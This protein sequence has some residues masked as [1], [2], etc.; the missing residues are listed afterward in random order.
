[1]ISFCLL[2]LYTLL[3][4]CLMAD[5]SLERV[6]FVWMFVAAILII[7]L[8]CMYLTLSFL[9]KFYLR[10]MSCTIWW[11]DIRLPSLRLLILRLQHFCKKLLLITNLF[12]QIPLKMWPNLYVS[13]SSLGRF[14]TSFELCAMSAKC[15]M[16]RGIIV[17]FILFSQWLIAVT[18]VNLSAKIRRQEQRKKSKLTRYQ[19]CWNC[20]WFHR[21]RRKEP[22]GQKPTLIKASLLV[23][24][25]RSYAN[26]NLRCPPV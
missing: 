7:F 8:S 3:F 20:E 11:D 18:K 10:L 13:L 17:P 21:I 16:P 19:T 4:L 26:A 2:L 15:C 6:I 22:R 1:M 9:D 24:S 25:C 14:A 12:V 5:W 23:F